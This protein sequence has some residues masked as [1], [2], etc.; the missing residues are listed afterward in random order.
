M[1][2]R[3][4]GGHMG[5]RKGTGPE[6]P[7]GVREGTPSQ[8]G[9]KT[10]TVVILVVAAFVLGLVLGAVVALLK[11][12]HSQEGWRAGTSIGEGVDSVGQPDFSQEIQMLQQLAQKDPENPDPWIRL[13]D[14]FYQSR[15]YG[16]AIEV[17]TKALDLRPA[18]NDV[19]IKLGN[20]YF[21]SEAYEEAIEAYSKALITDPNNTDVITDLGTAYRRT[22]KPEEAVEAFRK[23]ASIDPNHSTS[24]YN[25]GVVLFHDLNDAAGAIEAWEE[26]LRIEPVGERTDQVKRMIDALRKMSPS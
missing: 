20:T 6:K 8:R 25:L 13:G 4:L 16:K 18:R 15:R 10:E 26:F 21:D 7:K 1:S 23:A 9:V 19:R 12:P 11:A 22:G 3:R 17:Y 2:F 24:R 14:L 5:K